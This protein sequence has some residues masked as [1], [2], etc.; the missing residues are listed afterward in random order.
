M[1]SRDGTEAI[2]RDAETGQWRKGESGNPGGRPKALGLLVDK[3]RQHTDEAL[4]VLVDAMRTA[5]D[6]KV[7]CAAAVEILNR[8]WGR[9][10]AT[11]QRTDFTMPPRALAEA[12]SIVGDCETEEIEQP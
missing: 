11:L 1:M 3:A 6:I 5:K 7:R 4:S 2:K 10:I 8:G 12:D 9:P